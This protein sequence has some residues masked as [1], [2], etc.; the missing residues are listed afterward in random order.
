[1]LCPLRP[2]EPRKSDGR[3]PQAE[4]ETLAPDRGA[5]GHGL[6]LP[7]I[8]R[9]LGCSHQA[10]VST[11]RTIARSRERVRS[12]ACA[13]CREPIISAGCLPSDRGSALCL[14][15]LAQRPGVPFGRRLLAFRLAAGMT[16]AELEAAAGFIAGT[17]QRY[18]KQG[19]T[20]RWHRVVRLILVLG[21]QLV[22]LGFEQCLGE[23]P[24]DGR[25]PDQ[26]ARPKVY[27]PR[28][29]R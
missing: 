13:G 8:G 24:R 1:V 18:E 25:E 17:V 7:E 14:D 21:V 4:F 29:P 20:P 10:V 22:A 27:R 2:V 12:V 15:C 11:L 19:D 5:A 16:R 3:G 6:S 26:P 28:K 9:R 23:L